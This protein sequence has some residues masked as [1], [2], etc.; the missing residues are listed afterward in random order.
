MRP[1]STPFILASASPRRRELLT[2][3]GLQFEVV[4][5]AVPESENESLSIRELTVLNCTRK[6][7]AV[8]RLHPRAVILGADTLVALDGEVIGKP[9]DF[10]EAAQMLRR[11]SGR[12]HQVCTSV[13]IRSVE[14]RANFSVLSHV[15]FHSL[16]EKQIRAYIERIGSLD[17][18]GGY[19]AQGDGAEI[20]RGIRGSYTNVVGLPMDETL[21]VLERYF[22]IVRQQISSL[23]PS[24]S[25]KKKA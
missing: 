9:R 25:S 23:L 3:A 14:K 5:L 4:S 6:A 16:G 13:H 18:A 19:A 15:R 17:K 20:I 7:A 22:G 11:L 21:D 24:G 8:A 12:E 2:A 10:N 1:G